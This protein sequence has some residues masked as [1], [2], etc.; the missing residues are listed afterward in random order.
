[1]TDDKE[2]KLWKKVT[3][4]KSKFKKLIPDMMVLTNDEPVGVEIWQDMEYIFFS[5][6][7]ITFRFQL[8]DLIEKKEK[9]NP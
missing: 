3:K 7:C 6:G 1:M 2:K 8:S 4:E 5:I 9:K